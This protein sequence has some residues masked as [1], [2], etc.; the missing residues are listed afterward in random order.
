MEVIGSQG[1]YHRC[2]TKQRPAKP[3]AFHYGILR[4]LRIECR[5]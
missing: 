4:K 3:G 5:M 1:V 2:G